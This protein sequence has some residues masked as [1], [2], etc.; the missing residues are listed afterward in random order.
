MG[1]NVKKRCLGFFI[2]GCLSVSVASTWHE[3][4]NLAKHCLALYFSHSGV[5]SILFGYEKKSPS[6]IQK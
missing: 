5:F 4:G 6:L 2:T 3:I 1:R